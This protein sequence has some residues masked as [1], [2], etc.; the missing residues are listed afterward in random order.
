[1]RDGLIPFLLLDRTAVDLKADVIFLDNDI[2][3]AGPVARFRGWSP[4]RHQ[5]LQFRAAGGHGSALEFQ[6]SLPHG[7]THADVDQFF[8]E[9]MD[10]FFA[11]CL[12]NFRSRSILGERHRGEDKKYCQPAEANGVNGSR[13]HATT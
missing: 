5:P 8:V 9:G 12:T 10:N 2:A 13:L 3:D 6:S 4:E 1:M 11:R 7:K